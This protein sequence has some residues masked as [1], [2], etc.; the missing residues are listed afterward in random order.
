MGTCPTGPGEDAGNRNRNVL[1]PGVRGGSPAL[2]GG[3]NNECVGVRN[4]DD[5]ATLEAEAVTVVGPGIRCCCG[6]LVLILFRLA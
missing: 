1:L 6:V 2:L 3:R 5:C 4:S